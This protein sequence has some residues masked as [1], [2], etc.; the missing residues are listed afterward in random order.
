[1]FKF[2]TE[3]VKA[4]SSKFFYFIEMKHLLKT[5]QGLLHF[6][7]AVSRPV[8]NVPKEYL[9]NDFIKVSVSE[10]EFKVVSKIATVFVTSESNISD[11]EKVEPASNYKVYGIIPIEKGV[12]LAKLTDNGN[13][14]PFH[15]FD[16]FNLTAGMIDNYNED[17]STVTDVGKFTVNY[18]LFADVFKD[19]IPYQNKKLSPSKTDDLVAEVIVANKANREHYRKYMNQGY[20]F[21]E[22]GGVFVSAFTEKALTT[23]TDVLA[24]KKELLTKYKDQLDNPD[25]L[26]KIEAEL[27]SMDKAYLKNDP[28]D[29]FMDA[30]GKKAYNEARKKMFLTFGMSQ[31]FGTGGYKFT[32]NSLEDGWEPKYLATGANEV[33]RG[34][35]GR[36]IET[37]KGGAESKFILRTFQETKIIE[38]NCFD[39]RGMSV[40]FTEENID[41]YID[42]YL[43]NGTL[44]SEANKKELIGK[45]YKVR[46]PMTCK[47]KGGF[48]YQCCGEVFRKIQMSAIGMQTLEVTSSFTSAAM[49]TMHRSS[50]ATTKVTSIETFML[51]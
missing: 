13:T 37:A 51:K 48:C 12:L 34:S 27:I 40:T 20:W 14:N 30:C 4:V 42:R 49:S 38:D 46:S 35:Y 3:E 45:T 9:N 39:N 21:L 16:R 5:K 2:S 10:E 18:I 29:I 11:L 17:T 50:I 24:R 7:T 31:S 26:A 22:N 33:R 25:V 15:P 23:G 36:G 44:I 43:T 19:L 1:M 8:L 6:F 47:T 41:F 28:A 32:P